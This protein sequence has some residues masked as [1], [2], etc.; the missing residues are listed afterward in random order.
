ME[1]ETE[2]KS[3]RVSTILQSALQ[4]TGESIWMDF[5]R[6]FQAEHGFGSKQQLLKI[7]NGSE[8]GGQMG[9]LPP[10]AKSLGLDWETVKE[11][12]ILD[13]AEYKGFLK[14]SSNRVVNEVAARL[15]GLSAEEQRQFLRML[16][17][18][19]GGGHG[20]SHYSLKPNNTDLE[21]GETVDAEFKPKFKSK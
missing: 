16:K 18:R 2:V 14:K 21:E 3:P 20:S 17:I 8:F 10:M 9:L 12:L 5:V 15:E 4:E 7:I 19:S 13:K 11:A 1:I 6:R